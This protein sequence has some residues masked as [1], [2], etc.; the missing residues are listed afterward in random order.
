MGGI[1]R[2]NFFLYLF[3][4]VG[5]GL[6]GWPGKFGE[7]GG[8][9]LVESRCRRRPASFPLLSFHHEI[10]R[11]IVVVTKRIFQPMEVLGFDQENKSDLPRDS[12]NLTYCSSDVRYVWAR[13]GVHVTFRVAVRCGVPRKCTALIAC[14]SSARCPKPRGR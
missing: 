10:C 8:E 5:G 4:F 6:A 13:P 2:R 9:S 14:G 1:R 3:L 11:G 12:C 7:S